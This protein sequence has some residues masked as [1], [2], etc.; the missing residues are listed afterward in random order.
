MCTCNFRSLTD[1]P[2]YWRLN[3]LTN[4]PWHLKKTVISLSANKFDKNCPM[5]RYE[6]VFN[7]PL[8]G[9]HPGVVVIYW[10]VAS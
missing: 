6:S 2:F 8:S 7:D 1:T 9:N 3:S 5:F 4:K 10:T